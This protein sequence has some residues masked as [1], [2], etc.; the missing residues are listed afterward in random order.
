MKKTISIIFLVFIS[1]S[2]QIPVPRNA[3][4]AILLDR[5]VA[6]VNDEVI[7]WSELMSVIAFEGKEYLRGATGEEREKKIRE[8]E[9]PFL[10]TL[11]DTKLQ[12]E[13]AH[14][15]GLGVNDSEIGGAIDEIK[16]KFNVTD[17]GFL[18]SLK[19][20]R[21]TF[22]DYRARLA[23][24]IL[25]QKVVNVAVRSNVVVSDKEIEEYYAANKEKFGDEKENLKIRQILF[26]APED[27]SQKPAVEDRA[28][29]IM[30]RINRGEDF[31][32]LAKE[33]SEDPSRQFGGDLG[34]ISV[35]SALKEIEEEAFTLKTGEVSK[36]FWSPAGLHIIKLEDRI[37]GEG[38]ERVRDRINAILFQKAFE[39]KYHEWRTGLREKAYIEIK[40]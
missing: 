24:Q 22:K 6:T 25:I 2:F 33:F 35:G 13:E 9:R 38:I 21:L 32:Q 18:N 29:D 4:G 36:P 31:A 17:E 1:L 39:L 34:Y 12:V 8:I 15:I 37:K 40:L 23:D 5:V 28:R 14:R 20:E 26:V 30:Q 3:C 19:A 7:T 16:K 27:D 10:N 11:I